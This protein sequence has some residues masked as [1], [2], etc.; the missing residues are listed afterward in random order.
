MDIENIHKMRDSLR[1]LHTALLDPAS[2]TEPRPDDGL[3]TADGDGPSW[4][5]MAASVARPTSPARSGHGR[6]TS[7]AGDPTMAGSTF[8]RATSLASSMWHYRH[9]G[10]EDEDP[11]RTI[12]ELSNRA[13]AAETVDR[14]HWLDHVHLVL[15]AARTVAH[16]VE[17]SGN[18]CVVHCSDGWDRTPQLTSLAQLILDPYFRS[19]TGFQ[20]R[21]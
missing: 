3:A 21:S 18:P 14:S 19:F 13:V 15:R 17:A 8:D 4:P 11:S 5:G 12:T 10:D 1:A 16:L 9:T 6:G 2:P 7:P 20:V